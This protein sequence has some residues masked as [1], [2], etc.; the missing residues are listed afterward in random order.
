MKH[1]DD[2][3]KKYYPVVSNNR[4]N[5]ALPQLLAVRFT[6]A[7]VKSPRTELDRRDFFCGREV[8]DDIVEL[9]PD[10]VTRDLGRPRRARWRGSRT[11]F[12]LPWASPPSQHA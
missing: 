11:A 6:E 4:R 10:E 5:G 8:C 3:R 7:L 1:V 2:S 9:Y 12:A